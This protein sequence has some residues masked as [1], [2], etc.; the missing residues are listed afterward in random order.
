MPGIRERISKLREKLA[1]CTLC[2]RNC[3]VNRLKGEKGYCRTGLEVSVASCNLHFGEEPPISGERGSG[4]IFFSNC[5]LSC[6]FC[7][8]YPISQMGH[9]NTVTIEGL[10]AM[11]LDLQK[12]GAHNINFVT[13]SHVAYQAAEAVVRARGKGLEV[14]IAWNC[15]GYEDED[16]L[17]LLEGIIDIYM[18][19]AKYS[20][21]GNAKKYSDAANYPEIN[22]KALK[23]MHRQ[24]G[25]LRT[26][27]DGIAE[28]GLLVRHLVLPENIAGSRETL[29]FIAREISKDT[30]ISLMAQ[31]HP[32]HCADR[33]PALPR[34]LT[35][36]EYDEVLGVME[37]LGL[38]NGWQQEL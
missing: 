34:R 6:V 11:M 31:Y 32:A 4:T 26:D 13:P 30:F 15:G 25:T 12:R 22:R 9:G 3:R 1:P 2:P 23:E 8:N 18:P 21:G 10:A 24:A 36:E 37:R 7:Q 29:E 20:D 27:K 35:R 19:D 16:T 38:E 17:R 28:K 14:P 5:N 33:Y